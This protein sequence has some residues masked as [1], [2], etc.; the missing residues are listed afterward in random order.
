MENEVEETLPE[1]TFPTKKRKKQTEV[2]TTI[3]TDYSYT[4]LLARLFTSLR[5]DNPMFDMPQTRL[6]VPFPQLVAVGTKRTMWIN[7]L[8]TCEILHRL[9]DHLQ[10]FIVV[11]LCTTASIDVNG[12]L[13][14]RGRLQRQ[15]I[16]SLL[17]KYID[18]YV[19]C[20]VCK[21]TDTTLSKDPVSRLLF[22]ECQMCQSKRTVAPIKAGFHV[23]TSIDRKKER[24]E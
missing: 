2:T 5:R 11:E 21:Q 1:Y 7:F 13:V 20:G 24:I 4:E 16:E 3:E 12:R 9:V 14:I 19:K 8:K 17:T 23:T 15:K 10:S 6:Q 18:E 22:V